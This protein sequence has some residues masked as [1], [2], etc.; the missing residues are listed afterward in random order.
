MFPTHIWSLI[1]Q[2]SFWD[3]YFTPVLLKM[4]FVDQCWF[5]NYWL[6]ICNKKNI[7]IE[8]KNLENL[9]AT[10]H[11]CQ[12]HYQWVFVDSH[13]I[14]LIIYHCYVFHSISSW[15]INNNNNNNNNLV[16]TKD[17]LRSTSLRHTL[18]KHRLKLQSIKKQFRIQPPFLF[19]V[20]FLAI[21]PVVNWVSMVFCALHVPRLFICLRSL[22]PPHPPGVLLITLQTSVQ[23]PM[24]LWRTPRILSIV[25]G[26][27]SVLPQHSGNLFP[28]LMP[29]SRIIL[30][31]TTRI[32]YPCAVCEDRWSHR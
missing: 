19:L 10:W 7:E 23:R 17:N 22:C 1:Y 26:C 11:G 31:T 4:W 25:L 12:E 28:N 16:L 18:G 27:F 13:L 32:D 29:L 20:Y 5:T 8:S 9:I 21:S 15:Q 6:L 24:V 14:F 2:G 3:V 30:F